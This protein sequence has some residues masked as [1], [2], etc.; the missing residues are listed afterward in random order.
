MIK[1]YLKIAWRNLMKNKVF[2]LINIFGLSIGLTCCMLIS[3]YIYSEM[4]YDSYHKNGDRVYLLGTDFMMEGKSQPAA[5]S[6]APLGKTMQAEF[7]EIQ[8]QARIMQLF[9]DDKTLIRETGSSGNL[10]TFYETK[11]F[12]ADSNLFK[13]LTYFFKE[14]NPATALMEPNTVVI[15]E[16]IADKLFGNQSALNK[17]VH[18]S[19]ST[20]GDHDFKVTGVYRPAAG[21]SHI[22]AH[23]IMSMRGGRMDRMANDNPSMLNNN[24]FYTYLLLKDGADPGQLRAK[25]PGFIQ[26]HLA[27][28]LKA[29]GRQRKY[30]LA[31]LR[32]IY[33][34]AGLAKN[35]TTGGNLTSLY[36]LG[37]IAVLT[38]LIA[39]INFMNLS[40]SNSSKRASEVGVRKVLGAEKKS[41]LR[42]F[43]GE[44]LLL[45][46]IALLF[47]AL[48]TQLFLPV[49][50]K[51]S[52]KAIS[53]SFQQHALLFAGFIGLAFITGLLAGSY[54]AFYLSSFKPIEVLKG[55]FKN[56][57]AAVSLRKGMVVFQFVISIALIVASV[58]IASQ[59]KFMRSN[60]LGF[61]KDQQIILP[62]RTS[63]AKDIYT[64]LKN[65]ISANPNIK[66]VG[67]STYYPGIFN[68]TDWM[69]YRE[70]QTKDQAKRIYINFVDYD[71]L[72]TIGIQ[73]K[74]GRLFSGQFPS[75]TLDRF[76]INEQ[77]VKEFGFTSSKD[78]VGKWIG[79]EPADSQYRLTL[80]GV[81]KDF[82]FK[83]FH[84]P[85]EPYGFLLNTSNRFN[86]IMANAKGSDLSGTLKSL[87]ASWHKLN[88]NE[89]FEYSFLDEDFQK[90]FEEENRQSSLINYFTIISII[91]SCLGLFGLATFNAAQRT[92]EIGVRKV[93]GASVG[94]IVTLLSRDFLKLVGVAIVIACP[95]AWYVMDKWLQNFV[96]RTSV[97]WQ[98]FALTTLLAVAVA[99][100]TISFQA[101]KAAIA[102]PVKSLRTE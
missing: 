26:R 80:V 31:P 49:F 83:D 29:S 98:V 38:L 21:P 97:S 55:K 92:K 51:I 23:F 54:P 27:E 44:S 3:L 102:N 61:T 78:A 19:S 100:L 30:V 22:D 101:I 62:L 89:P 14:G 48:L 75:D 71:F 94:S 84:V 16:A 86:Y 87:E 9:S 63:T 45:A 43:L 33:L 5:N 85:I 74:E 39:C 99:V 64:A 7:P 52:G 12:L 77:A 28:E 37:S 81:V 79:F 56:S 69:V 41:L 6:A 73:P 70:G 76:I 40:T 11:G 50:E 72:R 32:D 93:L 42:Q 66:S 15:N 4:S 58:I 90:N 24:M 88:P 36:V 35:I 59:M 20:N 53:I 46:G 10:K 8:D 57:L 65:E 96:Y 47:A 34:R 91:I 25:F 95:I 67:A 1:N 60:N 13:I 82:H 17:V 68:P 18:I 2:S